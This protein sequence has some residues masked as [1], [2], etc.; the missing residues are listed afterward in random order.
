[1]IGQRHLQRKSLFLI[2]RSLFGFNFHQSQLSCTTVGS[3]NLSH[4]VKT[5][6][7]NSFVVFFLGKF[8]FFRKYKCYM[9]P[10]TFL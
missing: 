1:M 8:V 5:I 6:I 7:W 4:K 9:C 10:K 2:D 3:V